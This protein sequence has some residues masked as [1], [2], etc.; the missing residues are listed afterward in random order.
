M[1]DAAVLAV[2]RGSGSSFYWAMR[3][4][5][6]ER[7]R[8]MFAIYAFC[9]IV[10][11]IAD[12]PL[13]VPDKLAGLAHWRRQIE[14]LFAPGAALP[15]EPVARAL[16]GP[17]HRFD[18]ARTDFLAVIDGMETD[19]AQPVVAPG[20]SELRQYCGQVAGAVGLLSVRVFGMPERAA[21]PLS[22]AL[23]E[24]VQLTNI[25]RDV[26]DDAR[27]GRLYLPR[28]ELARA[29]LPPGPPAAVLRDPRLAAACEAVAAVARERFEAAVAMLAG[30]PRQ[31]ARPA[32]IMLAVYRRLLDRMCTRGFRCLEPR[33]RLAAGERLWIALRH[34]WF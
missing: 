17:I 5:P 33:V 2:V 19:A 31:P 32:R 1:S 9:R 28:E 21:R 23:G 34:T 10:D 8:A 15:D 14:R 7:R 13:P 6:R 24:A 11:D 25:L 30:L 29:G 4:L 22:V 26:A 12:G 16:V 3:L 18:L 27:D 20:W